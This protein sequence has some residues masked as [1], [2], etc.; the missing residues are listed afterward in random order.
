M[1]NYLSIVIGLKSYSLKELIEWLLWHKFIGVDHFY[2]FDDNSSVSVK[3]ALENYKNFITFVSETDYKKSFVPLGKSPLITAQ[4]NRR[5][6]KPTMYSY[7]YKKYRHESQWM[8]FIDDDE[9]IFPLKEKELKVFLRQV[10]NENSLVLQWRNFS[11]EGKSK[12]PTDGIIFDHYKRFQQGRAIKMIVNCKKVKSIFKK[13]HFFTS[14]GIDA[15]KNKVHLKCSTLDYLVKEP[16]FALN[17][18]SMKSLEDA[19]SK[20][21]RGYE[22]K[23][24]DQGLEFT[25]EKLLKIAVGYSNPKN[26][27]LPFNFSKDFKTLRESFIKFLKSSSE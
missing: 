14:Q 7:V 11:P 8:A 9:F 18:Y 3:R 27:N 16:Y 25:C 1:N 24:E 20:L 26:F 21:Y 13:N 2:I 23:I 19:K 4:D 10:E 12:T 17:H 6:Y 22:G 15:S 5:G